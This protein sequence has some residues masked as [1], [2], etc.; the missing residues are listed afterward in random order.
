MNQHMSRRAKGSFIVQSLAM[1]QFKFKNRVH[2]VAVTSL[3]LFSQACSG[4]SDS[5]YDEG[6]GGEELGNTFEPQERAPKRGPI[7]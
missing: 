2:C 3:S 5:L 1:G 6:C 4:D 7:L